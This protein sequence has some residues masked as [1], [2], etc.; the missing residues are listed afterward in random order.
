M[1]IPGLFSE[2]FGSAHQKESAL[3]APKRHFKKKKGLGFFQVKQFDY[4]W[5]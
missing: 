3:L 2:L 1:G 4:D 5:C